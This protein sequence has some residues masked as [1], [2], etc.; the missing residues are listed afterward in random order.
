MSKRRYITGLNRDQAML[1]PYRVE[2]FVP[3]SHPVR[4]IDAFVAGL[5]LA[6][7]GFSYSDDRISVGKPAY[8]PGALL[9]LYL[10]GYLNR[11][12]SSR[13]L[14]NESYRNLELIWLLQDLH[15]SY[16]TIADFRKDNAKAL[17]AANRHFVGVCKELEL[18][19][20]ELVGIDGSFFKGD[21]SQ[22]SVISKKQAQEALVRIEQDI[23]A[24][25]AALDK[26]DQAEPELLRETP[27]LQAKLARLRQ[28][29][30]AHKDA[31]QEMAADGASQVSHTD[32][33]ARR[34]QKQGKRLVGYNTQ[35]AVDAKHKLLVDVEVTNDGNDEQ[36]LAAM[37]TK[38]KGTLGSETLTV[39]ADAGY[40]N[41]SD[42]KACEEAGIEAYVAEPDKNSQAQQEGRFERADFTYDAEQ[43]HYTCPAGNILARSGEQTKG[44]KLNYRYAARSRDCRDC[45]LRERC[46]PRKTKYRQLYR[47]AH[48]AVVE[49]HRERM[50]KSG[51]V[52]MSMRAALAEHPFG[53]LKLWMGYNHFLTRGFEKVTGEMNLIG[54]C[55]NF[56]RALSVLG[57]PKLMQ[58]FMMRA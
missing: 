7:L 51:T 28:R 42:L 47:W 16:K 12:C 22:R 20:G 30:Q 27:D 45:P 40:Y 13:R 34:L 48:E 2:D 46:L 50:A 4:V 26:V 21:A 25:L 18:F 8:D 5:D 41:S 33:D 37:A 54:L 49:R 31:L 57:M 3:E 35:I 17:K 15:P 19:G 14:E 10:Y 11:I 44:D 9:K 24:Y 29:Q 23:E 38:A 39:V 1:L 43:D 32:P 56:K 53:T 6:K 58:Y 55:Y 52:M 36:Q